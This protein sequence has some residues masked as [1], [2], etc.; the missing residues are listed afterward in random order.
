MATRTATAD[1][2]AMAVA[3]DPAQTH[4]CREVGAQAVGLISA[5]DTTPPHWQLEGTNKATNKESLHFPFSDLGTAIVFVRFKETVNLAPFAQQ[6]CHFQ[7]VAQLFCIEK[8]T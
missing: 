2:V 7:D 3:V 8:L 5:I 1:P 6:V 4:R